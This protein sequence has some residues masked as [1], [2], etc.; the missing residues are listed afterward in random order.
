MGWLWAEAR[1]SGLGD[2]AH[3]VEK[4]WVWCIVVRVCAFLGCLEPKTKPMGGAAH[5]HEVPAAGQT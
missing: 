2:S 4:L 1:K 5:N 3:G